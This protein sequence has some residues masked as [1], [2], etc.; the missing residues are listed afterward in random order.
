MIL[1]E[2]YIMFNI[3]NQLSKL[4]ILKGQLMIA[5][6]HAEEVFENVKASFIS[7][8][9]KLINISQ[10]KAIFLFKIASAEILK[11]FLQTKRFSVMNFSE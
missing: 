6:K 10:I 5:D 4:K 11:S 1:I 3:S 2:F 9:K 8:V 7:N